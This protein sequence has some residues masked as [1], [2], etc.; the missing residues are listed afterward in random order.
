MAQVVHS[1][2][3]EKQFGSSLGP[4]HQFTVTAGW[5]TLI[6]HLDRST[7]PAR[8]GEAEQRRSTSEQN[9]RR[10]MTSKLATKTC[11]NDCEDEAMVGV[12]YG[13]LA[14]SPK[15]GGALYRPLTP[16]PCF[17]RSPQPTRLACAATAT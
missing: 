2:W 3:D 1:N 17:H 5:K 14:S 4:A 15:F 10:E 16:G 8:R 11:I 9:T 7:P 12:G 13:K 6:P